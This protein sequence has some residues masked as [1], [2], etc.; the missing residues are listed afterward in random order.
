MMILN[1]EGIFLKKFWLQQELYL[2]LIT[3]EFRT[4]MFDRKF[5]MGVAK[6]FQVWIK[7]IVDFGIV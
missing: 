7:I 3:D 4:H 6:C 5:N 2:I 1:Q